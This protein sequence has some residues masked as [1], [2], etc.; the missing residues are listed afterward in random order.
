MSKPLWCSYHI[1]MNC[2]FSH[3]LLPTNYTIC[4]VTFQQLIQHEVYLQLLYISN[5]ISH[6]NRNWQMWQGTVWQQSYI[7]KGSRN[8]QSRWPWTLRIDGAT[9]AEHLP[10]PSG[11]S[12]PQYA[13]V[14][15]AAGKKL[16]SDTSNPWDTSV[17]TAP[18]NKNPT[19]YTVLI[20]ITIYYC[21]EIIKTYQ[22]ENTHGLC[23]VE[24][25]DCPHEA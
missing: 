13:P 20:S 25:V 4:L 24:H 16:P 2:N 11:P 19:K 6:D 22:N 12:M 15:R 10:A 5:Y 18:N 8:V 17:Y 23:R 21:V 1:N 9:R 3:S 14:T 7:R